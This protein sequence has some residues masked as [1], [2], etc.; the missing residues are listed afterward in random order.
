M[1]LPNVTQKVA[2]FSGITLIGINALLL[3]FDH[4]SLTKIVNVTV[5]FPN[6]AKFGRNS[7]KF[8]FPLTDNCSVS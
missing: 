6:I 3:L 4:L 1:F 2:K 8:E 5:I 7:A